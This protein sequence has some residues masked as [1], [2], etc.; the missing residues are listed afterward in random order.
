MFTAFVMFCALQSPE[1]SP[2]CIVFQD[3][4]GP[5]RTEKNCEI[6]AAQMIREMTQDEEIAN[7]LAQHLGGAQI[8]YFSKCEKEEGEPV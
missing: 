3:S 8:Y 1:L 7:S 5:Y 6:R 4:Y 2:N